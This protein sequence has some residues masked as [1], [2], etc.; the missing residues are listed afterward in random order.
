MFCV[1][2]DIWKLCKEAD[3]R[4]RPSVRVAIYVVTLYNLQ[5]TLAHNPHLFRVSHLPVPKKL[6]PRNDSS[7]WYSIQSHSL[8]CVNHRYLPQAQ[9]RNANRG[10]GLQRSLLHSTCPPRPEQ[11][12]L[13][14]EGCD[15]RSGQESR[16]QRKF[17]DVSVTNCFLALLFVL[18][19]ES[20]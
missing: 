6:A 18:S 12:V 14:S 20:T 1:T 7:P 13:E 2:S 10:N 15:Q 19:C 3:A 11:A 5:S 17:H 9:P 16:A 8:P 4:M